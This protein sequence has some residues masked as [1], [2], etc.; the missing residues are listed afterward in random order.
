RPNPPL[1]PPPPLDALPIYPTP[2]ALAH[3]GQRPPE[4]AA[5]GE[6]VHREAVEPV[7]V[8]GGQNVARPSPAGHV[9]DE[10]IYTAERQRMRVPDGRDTLV[11]AE[12]GRDRLDLRPRR[13]E[14][15]LGRF[16]VAR[17]PG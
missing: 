7:R 3:A 11:R 15:S 16:E 13:A 5:V 9:V 2:A 1:S 12:I 10:H 14:L 17:R 6:H 8:G 4:E